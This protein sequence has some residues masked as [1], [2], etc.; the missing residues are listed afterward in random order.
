MQNGAEV[1]EP[2]RLGGKKQS[3][4]CVR[5]ASDMLVRLMN[6]FKVE[7]SRDTVRH[8]RVNFRNVTS[9]IVLLVYRNAQKDN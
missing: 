4:G 6:I 7:R 8:V 3:L 2:A 1:K 5:S 9:M